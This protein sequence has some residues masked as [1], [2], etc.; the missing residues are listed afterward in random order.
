WCSCAA[1]A[2]AFASGDRRT[3]AGAPPPAGLLGAATGCSGDDAAS[4]GWPGD[5]AAV[6]SSY[7]TDFTCPMGTVCVTLSSPVSVISLAELVVMLPVPVVPPRNTPDACCPG[8][9]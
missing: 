9:F 3:A 2:S 1:L 5:A 8:P 4:A 7:S 6:A